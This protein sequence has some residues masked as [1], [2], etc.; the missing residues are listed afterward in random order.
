MTRL[1]E[2]IP[3]YARNWVTSFMDERIRR[4]YSGISEKNVNEINRWLERKIKILRHMTNLP[5]EAVE[6]ILLSQ[7]NSMSFE[8][9]VSDFNR[10]SYR[11]AIEDHDIDYFCDFLFD[12]EDVCT[13]DIGVWYIIDTPEGVIFE[14]KNSDMLNKVFLFY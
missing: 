14:D 9:I 5:V 1:I 11:N 2:N 4:G 3:P 12:I 6:I 10:W 8:D 13:T 7:I